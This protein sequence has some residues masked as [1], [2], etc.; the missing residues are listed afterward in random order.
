MRNRYALDRGGELFSLKIICPPSC[1]TVESVHRVLHA[2]LRSL[3]E[4]QDQRAEVADLFPFVAMMYPT[5]DVP[6]IASSSHPCFTTVCDHVLLRM[7][8]R[9]DGICLLVLRLLALY[10]YSNP[11]MPKPRLTNLE[12][13]QAVWKSA[14][15]PRHPDGHDVERRDG[16]RRDPHDRLSKGS[17]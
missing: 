7:S 8:S 15:M 13:K 14:P 9:S 6:P 16:R 4:R 5:D 17:A 11:T 1:S 3:F 12:A 2:V 10:G